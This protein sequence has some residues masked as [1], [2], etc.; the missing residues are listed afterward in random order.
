MLQK[1]ASASTEDA[2]I[3]LID[4]LIPAVASQY[5]E[6]IAMAAAKWYEEV[7]ADALPDVDDGF[8]ALLA[9][10]YSKKAIVEEIHDHILSNRNK[11]D[12][13]IVD[14][15][16]RWIKIPG[17]ATIAENC[18]RDPKKP[19]YALVPQGKTC[20]FCTMLACRG[21]VYESEKTAHKMHDHCDCVA[22][23]EWDANPNKIRGYNP[24][25]LSDEWDKAKKIVWAK[26]KAE[27][28]ENGEDAN[29]VFEPSSK[30]ILAQLRKTPG[31]CSDGCKPVKE[32]LV[33]H[34][35][36]EKKILSLRWQEN[37]SD[38]EW[39][40]RQKAVGVDTK[41]D[42]LYPHE[43]VFL[44]KFKNA[45]NKFT[46][47]PRDRYGNPTNDFIWENHS[48]GAVNAELKSLT[49]TKYATASNRISKAVVFAKKHGVVKDIF[50]IDYGNKK[51]KDKELYQLSLYNE[52]NVNAPIKELWVWQ[53]GTFAEIKLH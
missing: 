7:R 18:K 33:L 13:A 49:S 35:P 9:Q 28:R 43:I 2:R 41:T 8:E 39:I 11:F 19:R 26:N 12:E 24:D 42:S 52:R 48:G 21:F 31:L 3:A 53:N 30:E 5:S 23:P 16:D 46:W 25:T 51:L 37:V 20:A 36:D 38:K 50:I 44:E 15:M 10:T 17:R 6:Q 14:A 40:K 22:C 4:E 32:M 29:K 34:S 1:I 45:G 47:I 27:A